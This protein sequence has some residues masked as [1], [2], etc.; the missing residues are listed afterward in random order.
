MIPVLVLGA[1]AAGCD[2]EAEASLARGDRLMAQ[3]QVDA[4][5]AEYR[6][7][8]RQ[9]GDAPEVLARL[10][11]AYAVRGDVGTS[12]Q[13]YEE[14]VARDSSWRF[15]AASDLTAAAREALETAGRDRMARALRPL[16]PMGL[17]LIPRDLRQELAGYHA[18]RQ[19]WDAAL[20][21]YLSLFQEEPAPGPAVHYRTARAYQEL[22]GCREALP[23]FERYLGAREG[24]GGDEGGV[25]WHYGS[26][27]YQVA[28]EDW[29]SGRQRE[30]LERLQRLVEVGTP[31][32]VMDRAHFLRGELLVEAGRS[33]EAL[34]AFREVLRLNPA[35]SSPLARSAEERVREIRYGV[36]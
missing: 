16:V 28:Q 25:L 32:T 19:E 1:V 3:E 14:L 5:V 35:R 17:E 11:H 33:E 4:A 9:R 36:P 31:R 8:R 30:A 24:S 18:D 20:P 26:C 7:A 34:A 21:L 29:R 23:F 10:A 13:M 2:G 22:G 27:L 15:H 12:Q 6:L